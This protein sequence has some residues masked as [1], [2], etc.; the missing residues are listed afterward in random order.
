MSDLVIRTVLPDGRIVR[1]SYSFFGGSMGWSV[2]GAGIDALAGRRDNMFNKK[3]ADRARD[4]SKDMA[5]TEMQRRV[6]DLK[7]AGLNPM[8]AITEGA[9]STPSSAQATA[10][11][12]G[13]N[14]AGAFSAAQMV[15]LAK[16]KNAA[17]IK[18]IEANTAKTVEETKMLADSANYSAIDAQSR[19]YALQRQAE[20]LRQEITQVALQNQEKEAF[21]DD[22][23][24]LLVE[25][26]RIMNRLKT[27]EIPESEA[28]AKFFKD[29]GEGSKWAE[30][31]K[32]LLI[33]VRQMR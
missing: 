17:E 12:K 15:R 9:A 14:F 2:L 23:Q 5:N 4:W 30:L 19:S 3:E 26:Q 11:S 8:L 10:G 29:V 18:Q 21:L 20:K 7:A 25:Y 27:L 16:E 13:T 31:I 22:M 32:S 6:N 1:D 28:T 33:G 24:P